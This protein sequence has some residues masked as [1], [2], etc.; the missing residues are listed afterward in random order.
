MHR[1]TG[2]ARRLAEALMADAGHARCLVVNAGTEQAAR[3]WEALAFT[4]DDRDGHTHI[5]RRGPG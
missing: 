2:V 1:R 3:F 5:L 4:P